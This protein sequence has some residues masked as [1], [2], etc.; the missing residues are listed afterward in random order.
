M[1]T[2]CA[3]MSTAHVVRPVARPVVRTGW[4]A[5]AFLQPVVALEA[6]AINEAKILDILQGF[7]SPGC[8]GSCCRSRR[9]EDYEDR[10]D[11][12]GNVDRAVRGILR[13]VTNRALNTGK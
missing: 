13:V 5:V 10:K 4:R 12:T 8:T 11:R 9:S 1:L 7:C 6:H 3:I 2:V